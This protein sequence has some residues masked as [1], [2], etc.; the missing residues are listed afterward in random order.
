MLVAYLRIPSIVVTLA[1]MVA[2]RDGLR[3][4][5][6][7][8]WVQDLPAGFQWLGSRQAIYPFLAAAIAAALADRPVAWTLGNLRRRARGL[9]HRIEPDGGA[10]GRNRAALVTA[11]VFAL[12]GASPGSPRC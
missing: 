6:Q 9:R 2:L 3:W 5:T 4:I 7:G 1:M 12:A 11:S 8:E 10:P